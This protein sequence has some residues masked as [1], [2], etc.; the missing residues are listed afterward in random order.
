MEGCVLTNKMPQMDEVRDKLVDAVLVTFAILIIP[1]NV[2]SWSRAYTIGV[3]PVMFLQTAMLVVLCVVAFLRNRVPPALKSSVILGVLFLL[4][5]SG[6]LTFG[7][8][9]RSTDAFLLIAVLTTALL[10]KRWGWWSIVASGAAAAGVAVCVA[11][12]LVR[13]PVDVVDYVMSPLSWFYSIVIVVFVSAIAVTILGGVLD[14][15][16]ASISAL[17]EQAVELEVARDQAEAANRSKSVFMANVSHEFRTPLNAVVGYAEIHQ[18]NATD[19]RMKE[20][21]SRIAVSG[22]ALTNLVE[23][24][25]DLSRMEAGDLKPDPVPL[26]MQ[27]FLDSHLLRYKKSAVE[28]GLTFSCQAEAGVPERVMMD[29]V[30]VGKAL[31][32][33]L[34]NA[35]KFTDQGEIDVTVHVANQT[36]EAVDLTIAV[37]DTGVGIPEDQLQAIMPPFTQRDGLSI[38]D[39]GGTGIGLSLAKRL[40][41]TLGGRLTVESKEGE[42]SVFSIHFTDLP[43]TESDSATGESASTGEARG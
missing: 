40:V 2:L 27:T 38:N 37:R 1:A 29:E 12:G 4:A 43:V 5:T 19:E 26:E 6:L 41:E 9:S 33:L 28:K 35:I 13:I 20:D 25:L 24:I 32:H 42:G 34:D 39:Y 14:A 11:T 36:D 10:G 17:Q 21:M 18:R 31:G 7:L 23:S 8:V 30:R 22:R 3:Q 15:L 16:T